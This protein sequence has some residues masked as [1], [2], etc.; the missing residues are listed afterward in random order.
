MGVKNQ[1]AAALALLS[2]LTLPAWAGPKIESWHTSNGARVM[3]VHAPEI[4]MLDLRVVF[5]AGSVRDSKSGVASLTNAMLDQGAGPW[6]ADQIAERM[7]G[8]GAELGNGA[9]RD[10]AWVTARTL[11]RQP[12]LRTT[13]GTLAAVLG[14]PEFPQDQFERLRKATLVALR[15]DEQQP[16]SV[17][18]KAFYRALFGDHPYAGDP[19]GDKT[20]VEALSRDELLDF[21][22]RHY[23]ARNAVVAMVGA[24]DRGEAVRIAERITAGLAE[25]EPAPAV[26]PV[27]ALSAE[28][29]QRLDFPSSQSHLFAGQPG[30]R[31]GDPD[32]FPLYVGNHVLGGNGLVSQLSQEVREK[33]GLSYS[34]YS[35]FLL[36]QQPG[37]F[38]MGL[39][40]KNS[41]VDGAR[42]VAMDTLKRFREQGPT[43]EE[44]TAAKQNITGGFPLRIANN[45]KIIQY[46]A[47]IGFY[48]LPLDYLDVFNSKIDAVTAEQVRDAFQRRLDPER[49]VTVV[50]GPVDAPAVAARPSAEGAGHE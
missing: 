39:Q 50:V 8:V 40:T 27:A 6:N 15:Q 37:P 12:A 26:P 24:I 18:K 1:V 42:Q 5:K 48:D 11:T 38:M 21:Y 33:R 32:Y 43:A 20:S 13:L 17:G 2:M 30:I 19:L 25:G 45:S 47:M 34:V 36:M 14:R 49:F 9:K 35:Y 10:M 3:F 28:Q 31:R 22:R 4:P 46:L 7:E 44:L 29:L 41:Q 23:V 16:D